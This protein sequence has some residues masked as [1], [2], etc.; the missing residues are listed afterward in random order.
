MSEDKTYTVPEAHRFFGIEF[1]GQV[2]GLLG[3]EG[4]SKED[5]ERM[6]YSAFASARHW[7]E[8]GTGVNHQRGE[9]MISHAYADLGIAE[10]ALRHAQRCLE[11]TEQHAEEME[12]FDKAYAYEAVAR[13]LAISGDREEALRYIEL[14]DKAG[15][16]IADP[17]S[18]KYF[19]SDF[20]GG[21]WAGLK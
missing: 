12:D 4:R 7:L 6:I 3:K 19:E 11:L 17:E 9:W 16:S 21:D 14:A 5:A 18:K 13:A 8:A 1:N 15:Q 2:W 10:A 20:A